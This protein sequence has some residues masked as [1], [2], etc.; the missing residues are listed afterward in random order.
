MPGR[1]VVPLRAADRQH[2]HPRPG[3][4]VRRNDAGGRQ[5]TAG[6]DPDQAD[7]Q[8]EVVVDRL[9]CDRLDVVDLGRILAVQLAVEQVD[10]DL[11]GEL[12]RRRLP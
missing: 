12:I 6:P 10:H 2:L 3:L 9:A 5:S 11:P 7:V 8:G 4:P 1:G